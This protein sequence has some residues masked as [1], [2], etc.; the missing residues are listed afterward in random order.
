[1]VISVVESE[2]AMVVQESVKK[3]KHVV[4]ESGNRKIEEQELTLLVGS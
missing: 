4:K 2:R 3:K 1:M